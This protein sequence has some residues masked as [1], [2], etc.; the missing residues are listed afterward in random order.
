MKLILM[1]VAAGVGYHYV[2]TAPAKPAPQ[3][4][5]TKT[6][7]VAKAPQQPPSELD[8]A[9]SMMKSLFT[10]TVKQASNTAGEIK[11]SLPPQTAK[12][13]DVATSQAVASLPTQMQPLFGNTGTAC[14]QPDSNGN[15]KYCFNGE[16]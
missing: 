15:I 8:Q 10:G 12:Q 14:G 6:V 9:F 4:D 1:L 13:I 11:D 16:R 2:T 3:A 7:Q 5:A